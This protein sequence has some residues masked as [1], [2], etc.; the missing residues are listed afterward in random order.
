[1]NIVLEKLWIDNK[2]FV[3]REELKKILKGLNKEYLSTIRY[4]ISQRYIARMW[5]KVKTMYKYQ[6][7]NYF[8]KESEKNYSPVKQATLCVQVKTNRH[9][10]T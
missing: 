6:Y 8:K 7:K 5:L 4:L 9:F 10:V 1:M 3:T 2:K